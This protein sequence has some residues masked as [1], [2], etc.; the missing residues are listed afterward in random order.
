METRKNIFPL[1]SVRR[2][3]ESCRSVI[4][5]KN[6]IDS[7]VQTLNPDS[8]SIDME[9]KNSICYPT[10]YIACLNDVDVR[11]GS[12]ILLSSEGIALSD[13]IEMAFREFRIRPKLFEIEIFDG[14]KIG[15]KV[16]PLVSEK[17]AYGIHLTGE[18]EANYFHWVV[19]VLPRLFIYENLNQEKKI[20]ILVSDGLNNNLYELLSAVLAPE[21]PIIKLKQDTCYKI[22]TLMYPSDLSRILDV[23][24]RAPDLNSTYLPVCILRR[25]AHNIKLRYLQVIPGCFRKLF[26]KR[27]S[28]YRKLLNELEIESILEQN[29][30]C[31]LD[32][33]TLSISEQINIFSQAEIIV[34][35]SGAAMTNIIWCNEGTQVIILHSD[36]PFKNY[37][38]W[39]ALARTSGAKLSYLA[40]PRANNVTGFFQVHDDYSIDPYALERLLREQ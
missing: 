21:R 25:M 33:G 22:E 18:H 26:I 31:S 10:P 15:F 35:S 11:P 28:N 17:I 40:G 36:H 38:Y 9:W 27:S 13:E 39:D 29:G 3:A 32:P 4:I 2:Y 6:D 5:D 37:P 23:Y 30:F 20:P 14:P 1:I 7:F 12:R 24:D 19:E 34:G 8:S 16:P